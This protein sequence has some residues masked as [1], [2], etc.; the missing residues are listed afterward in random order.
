MVAKK[1]LSVHGWVWGACFRVAVAQ[2]ALL[3]AAPG[4]YI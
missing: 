1:N 2:K 3:V 4:T